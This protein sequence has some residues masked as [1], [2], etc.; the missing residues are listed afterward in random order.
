MEAR[1]IRHFIRSKGVSN[2]DL[3]PAVEAV[4]NIE[5]SDSNKSPSKTNTMELYKFG[6]A[7]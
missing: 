3:G 5:N 7:P 4:I 1:D 6:G 2:F